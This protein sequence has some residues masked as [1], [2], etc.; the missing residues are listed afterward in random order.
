MI[1]VQKT[2]R[3][4]LRARAWLGVQ[5]TRHCIVYVTNLKVQVIV[6]ETGFNL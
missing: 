1:I 4:S 6:A 3:S 5:S 2:G